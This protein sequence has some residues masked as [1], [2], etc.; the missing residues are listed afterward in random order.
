MSTIAPEDP[1][2]ALTPPYHL[3]SDSEKPV[4]LLNGVCSANREGPHSGS[5]KTSVNLVTALLFSS[6]LMFSMYNQL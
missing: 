6:V 1:P 4:D 2:D 5:V 3:K